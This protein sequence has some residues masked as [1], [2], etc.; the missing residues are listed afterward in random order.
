MAQISYI[1]RIKDTHLLRLGIIEEGE[2]VAYTVSERLFF[3]LSGF[4]VGEEIDVD[5]LEQIKGEDEYYTAKKKALSLLSYSDNNERNLVNKLC[6]RGIGPRVAEQ[7]AREMVSLGY[8]N[9]ERQLERII[10]NEANVKLKGQKRIVSSLLSKGYKTEKIKEIMSELVKRG[11]IDFRENAQRLI[12]K[13]LGEDYT[14]DERAALLY[15]SGY[16]RA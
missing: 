4:S 15:K 3:E 14:D 11:E 6:M 7:V 16:T 1:R 13:K 2:K 5:T 12:D 10:L 8:I 9:E